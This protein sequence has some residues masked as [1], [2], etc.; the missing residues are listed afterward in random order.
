MYVVSWQFDTYKN[1]KNIKG[2]CGILQVFLHNSMTTFCCH[3]CAMCCWAPGGGAHWSLSCLGQYCNDQRVVSVWRKE[4][5]TETAITKIRPSKW[6]KL[7]PK[8]KFGQNSCFWPGMV[9]LA[10][11]TFFYQKWLFWPKITAEMLDKN[12]TILA[13]ISY[14]SRE[15]KAKHFRPN[16]SQN[17][18]PLCRP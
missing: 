6:L 5:F 12:T 16:F 15:P 18:W 13:E 9:V 14:F 4:I 7:K 3:N 2:R 17:F 11:I 8:L 10:K 1:V